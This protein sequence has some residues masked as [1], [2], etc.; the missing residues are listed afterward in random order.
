MAEM[1]VNACYAAFSDLC[2]SANK[3]AIYHSTNNHV[4]NWHTV[5]ANVLLG[6]YSCCFPL[7]KYLAGHCDN[8]KTCTFDHSHY[9]VTRH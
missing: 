5:S 4:Y 8:I 2:V 6:K 9:S 7:D 3:Q 1:Y